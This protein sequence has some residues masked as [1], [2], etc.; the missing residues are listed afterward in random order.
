MF[1]DD[2]FYPAGDPA[3]LVLGCP[4]TLAHARSQGKGPPFIRLGGLIVYR[5]SDLNR[6]LDGPTVQPTDG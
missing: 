4:S 1:D 3:L 2:K 6:W 5:G